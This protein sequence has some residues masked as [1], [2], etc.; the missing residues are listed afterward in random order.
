MFPLVTRLFFNPD[1]RM[2]MVCNQ[3]VDHRHI[4]NLHSAVNGHCDF[5]CLFIY[6]YYSYYL[7]Y[8]YL[9]LY[10]LFNNQ[11]PTAELGYWFD[12]CPFQSALL[13]NLGFDKKKKMLLI[14]LFNLLKEFVLIY[15]CHAILLYTYIPTK[16]QSRYQD[17]KIPKKLIGCKRRTCFI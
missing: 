14:P 6:S 9:L 5:I 1:R 4:I 10:F 11:H 17:I 3:T 7:Y 12:K 15:D 13:L 2:L 8:S 16:F